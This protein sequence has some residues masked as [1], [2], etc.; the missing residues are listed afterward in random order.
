MFI[1]EKIL[2]KIMMNAYKANGLYM[3]NYDGY[4]YLA[5]KFHMSWE[6][7]IAVGCVPNT[8]LA[9]MVECSGGVPQ[10]G[11]GWTSDKEGSQMEAY[12]VCDLSE[13]ENPY[14]IDQ[15][16]L[17]LMGKNGTLY[18]FMQLQHNNRLMLTNP[19]LLL[20]IDPRSIDRQNEETMIEGPFYDGKH[21]IYAKTNQAV[22]RIWAGVVPKTES[23]MDAMES[24]EVKYEFDEEENQ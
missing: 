7:K 14:A 1:N 2:R 18:R 19:V 13:P 16:P 12:N 10:N 17:Y 8:I 21:G 24:A 3:G 6:A 4:Y 20:A 22:F 9:A 23:I 11:E 15:T 5:D